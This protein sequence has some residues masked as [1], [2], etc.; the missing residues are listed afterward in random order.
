[1][2]GSFTEQLPRG[3]GDGMEQD[4]TTKQFSDNQ[5]ISKHIKTSKHVKTYQNN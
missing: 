2:A 5:N 3:G 4:A 1:L